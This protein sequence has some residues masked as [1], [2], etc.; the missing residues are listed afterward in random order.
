MTDFLPYLLAAL[1]YLLVAALYWRR[2]EFSNVWS[3]LA[4]G[5]A[6]ALHG[7]L[8]H[9]ALV[10]PE[11]MNLGL[12]N[13]LSAIFWLTALFY[14]VAN[15]F[16]GLHRLQAFVLPPTA[17]ALLLQW[18]YPEMHLL[19]YAQEPLFR[20]HLVIAFAAYSLFTFAAL[21][22]LLMA[23]AERVLHRKT[24]FIKLPDFPPLISMENLLFQIIAAGFTL[25]TLTLVSGVLFSEQLF[26]KAFVFNHKNVFTMVS[27]LTFGGLLLGRWRYGWR[28]KRAVHWTLAG[29]G[30]LLLAYLGSKFVL[31]IV[32]GRG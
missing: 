18:A 25:L 17:L 31:E 24:T 1:I 20:A 32:L 21:H 5:V 3:Q 4:V 13:A 8:L 29:F 9:R 12:T 22:A 30:I 28:G 11:G 10:L 16:H 26:H 27:W 14:W 6:L 2:T 7:W 23:A 15:L 19:V